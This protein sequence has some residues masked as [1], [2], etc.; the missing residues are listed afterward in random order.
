MTCVIWPFAQLTVARKGGVCGKW[1]KTYLTKSMI[2]DFIARRALANDSLFDRMTRVRQRDDRVIRRYW[3]VRE[4]G[5][6]QAAAL[7]YRKSSGS[8]LI[9]RVPGMY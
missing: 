3:S 4:C 1:A 9:I 2:L 6:G 8:D 7:C 5:L